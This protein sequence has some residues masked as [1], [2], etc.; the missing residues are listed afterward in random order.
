M[1]RTSRT[2]SNLSESLH[3]RLNAYA[4]A[5]SAA[6][7]GMLALAQPAEAKVIYTSVHIHIPPAQNYRLDINQDGITDFTFTNAFRGWSSSYRNWFVEGAGDSNA[8]VG[9]ASVLRR[10]AVIGPRDAFAQFSQV[11]LEGSRWSYRT[12]G[13]GGN[14]SNSAVG[15]NWNRKDGYLG[16]KFLVNGKV[17][18]GWLRLKVGWNKKEGH[19]LIHP[20]LQGYAYETIPNKPIIAG[21]TRGKDVITVEPASLG[22]LARGASAIP[23]WRS[24]K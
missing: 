22:H 16:L 9:D 4:L 6:G 18:Y 14:C 10:G 1:K 11:M 20:L 17:H 13:G 7:V 2:P 3:H 15:G 21:K 5:A 8:V 12:S 23:A 24:G 19:P